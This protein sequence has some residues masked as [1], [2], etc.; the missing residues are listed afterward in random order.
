MLLSVGKD[1]TFGLYNNKFEL[2]HH[3]EIHLRAITS[4]GFSWDE[5]YVAT[6][7][8]DK[9]VKVVEVGSGEVRAVY[10]VK[11]A[12]HAVRWSRGGYRIAIGTESGKVMVLEVV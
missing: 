11:E 4:G 7:S 10:E 12:V 1:R 3:K 5:K 2:I 9:S 8:R 6:G